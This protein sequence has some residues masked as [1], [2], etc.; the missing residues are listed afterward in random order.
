ML[1]AGGDR[2]LLPFQQ[3]FDIVLMTDQKKQNDR[4]D[5]EQQIF[6]CMPG[7]PYDIGADQ[8]RDRGQDR[9]ERNTLPDK[10][11]HDGN[12]R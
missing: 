7:R 4:R 11:D 6:V 3:S 2:F 1:I 8:I 12:D 9:N 5:K 10:E